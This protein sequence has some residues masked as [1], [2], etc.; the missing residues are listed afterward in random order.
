MQE[1]VRLGRIAG[2]GVGMNWSVLVVFWLI[3]WSL[4]AALF[5][6]QVPGATTA[7]YW[8]AGVGTAVAFF[9]SLLAH[10]LGHAVVARRAGT[11][12][13]GHHLVAAGR[14]GQAGR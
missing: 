7:A 9:A 6:Q 11:A 4:A 10:E 13:R 3:C 5:P 12:G 2:I 8:T 14:G 1:S